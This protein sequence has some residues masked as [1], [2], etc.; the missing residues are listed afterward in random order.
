MATVH[1][2]S[3]DELYEALKDASRS[4]SGV[5]T[6]SR[7]K[8]K[9]RDTM[10]DTNELRRQ[11]RIFDL[12]TMEE[13]VLVKVGSFTPATTSE[14]A[15]Q[16]VGNDTSKFLAIINEGLEAEAGRS[17]VTD[18]TVAWQA[19]DEEGAIVPF[20]GTPANQKSVNGLILNL[21]KTIF[22]FGKVDAKSSQAEKDANKLKNRTA[23]EKAIEFI[24]TNDAIKEGLKKNAAAEP[25]ETE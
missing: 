5:L 3:V 24:K 19:E 10:A 23:K 12:D 4:V 11:R 8:R 2:P 21:A 6:V 16:R 7:A 15:L 22:G 18:N 9:K 13:V 17:L 25:A 20:T 1:T 14:E